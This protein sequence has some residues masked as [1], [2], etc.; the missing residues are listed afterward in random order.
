MELKGTADCPIPDGAI[1]A[2]LT[3]SDRKTLRYALFPPER[4]EDTAK[5]KPFEPR[6]TICLF[7]GRTEFIEKYFDVIRE[8]QARGFYVATLDW[9]GQGLSH[10]RFKNRFRGHIKSFDQ[11]ELDL[12]AFTQRVIETCPPPYCALAHSM[13]AHILLRSAD[14]GGP[15]AFFSRMILTAPMLH[16]APEM[17]PGLHQLRKSTPAFGRRIVPQWPARWLTGM[18]RAM[19]L[20]GFYPPGGSNRI[21]FEFETNPLTTDPV[22][23]EIMMSMMSAHP[24]LTIGSPTIAWVNAACRSMR[25]VLDPAFAPSVK[26]PMLIIASGADKIVSTPAIQLFAPKIR[27]GR[28]VVIPG[29]RHEIMFE[30]DELRL[31]FWAAFDAYITH[32]EHLNE[33]AREVSRSGKK[34][35]TPFDQR[36]PVTSK[37]PET[38]NGSKEKAFDK[39]RSRKEPQQQT[40]KEDAKA[41]LDTAAQDVV[42][43]QS[44]ATPVVPVVKVDV[45]PV[46]KVDK[47]TAALPE[48]TPVFVSK[49]TS[50]TEDAPSTPEG[51]PEQS[52]REAQE[53]QATTASEQVEAPEQK[54]DETG[55]NAKV[56]EE[57]LPVEPKEAKPETHKPDQKGEALEPQVPSE[58]EGLETAKELTGIDAPAAPESAVTPK[59]EDDTDKSEDRD[60][61]EAQKKPLK[62]MPAEESSKKSPE[63]A[64]E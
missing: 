49:T 13:G 50:K 58:A 6:G 21:D 10:R 19:G 40:Q 52:E 26:V 20:G 27:V 9:R 38:D 5:G 1:V 32:S 47:E 2:S 28:H 54:T 51:Q 45:V 43:K 37:E 33:K 56:I 34:A 15:G 16:L 29:A 36:A 8:L 35:K 41:D 61:D 14:E 48:A 46:V 24:D 64:A 11:Y 63:K 31:Q 23:F 18:L 17:L 22:R 57:K 42:E 44:A 59:V 25:K 7:Q 55:A 62:K 12:E 4:P 39:K 60:P 30:R 53:E 3:T